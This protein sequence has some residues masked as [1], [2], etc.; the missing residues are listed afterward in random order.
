MVFF[1]RKDPGVKVVEPAKEML[2][3]MV[4]RYVTAKPV[5][6]MCHFGWWMYYHP[7]FIFGVYFWRRMN[8]TIIRE[9]I[10]VY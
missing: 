9:L 1:A 8:P 2:L 5:S 6:T 10:N 4:R 7:I 3:T